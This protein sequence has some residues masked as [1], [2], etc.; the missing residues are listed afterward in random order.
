MTI[1]V[2]DIQQAATACLITAGTTYRPDQYAAYQAA[3]AR[4][5]LENPRWVMERIVENARIAA[6]ETLPLCDDTGIPH[7]IVRLGDQCDVPPG[8]LAALQDGV[9]EGLRRMPG[10][11]MAVLGDAIERVEQSRGLDPDPGALELAPVILRPEKGRQLTLTVLLLGGGP[12]IRARTR[13]IFHRRSIDTVL[14]EVAS[15]LKEEVGSLGCTPAV[16]AVGIGRSHVE[17]SALM[18]EAMAEGTLDR[19]NELE[20]KVTAAVN[21]T[22]VGPLGLGGATTLLGCYL[23]I[24]PTRAS[25]VRIVCVRPCCLVEPRRATVTLG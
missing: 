2:S 20:R 11:P 23:K 5:P 17:A 8:W 16:A 25:G 9:I 10:R 14:G 1:T 19:Q 21:Q 13:R 6:A 24:G 3:I 15:W 7:V 4:E 12:E 18:L 22:E